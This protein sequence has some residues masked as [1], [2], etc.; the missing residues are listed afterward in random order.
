MAIM[1]PNESFEA[2][3]RLPVT[4]AKEFNMNIKNKAHAYLLPLSILVVVQGACLVVPTTPDYGD[5]SFS[6]NFDGETSCRA[7]RVDEL[8]IEIYDSTD[9]KVFEDTLGCDGGSVT[10]TRFSPDDYVIY[11]D[12]YNDR[13][14]HLFQGNKSISVEADTVAD[15]GEITMVRTGSS[16]LGDI[17]FSWS[18]NGETNCESAGVA[19][20][21]VGIYDIDNSEVYINTLECYGSGV[22]I[23]D[24]A[25]GS[26][27]VY[28]DAYGPN[29]TRL[30]SG[31]GLT[32]VEGGAIA[33]LGTLELDSVSTETTGHLELYWAFLYPAMNPETDCLVAGV[34]EVDIVLTPIGMDSPGYETTLP[35]NDDNAGIV[36]EGLAAGN[37]QLRLWGYSNFDDDDLLLY[38]SGNQVVEIVNNQVLDLGDVHMEREESHFADIGV[39]WIIDCSALDI[40]QVDL[41]ITRLTGS[42]SITD[43]TFSRDCDSPAVLRSTFVPGSYRIEA[44]AEDSNGAQWEGVQIVSAEPGLQVDSQLTLALEGD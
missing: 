8:D 21:D 20:I 13:N 30:F 15:A 40:E 26:Y 28:L 7:A 38:D 1:D 9:T 18:F 27:S 44:H 4:C 6:W 32:Y 24:F 25:P 36:I 42:R 11:V 29:N 23:L 17:A 31:D 34:E 5:I 10:V 2:K 37:Y 22:T 3:A 12:A 16:V 41:T 14:E 19:E 33:D 35:C 43:D 39:H